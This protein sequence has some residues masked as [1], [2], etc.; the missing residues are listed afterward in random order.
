MFRIH[1]IFGFCTKRRLDNLFG[2]CLMCIAWLGIFGTFIGIF[3]NKFVIFINN[4]K[5]PVIM[6]A[7]REYLFG[8][9]HT[10]ANQNTMLPLWG[11]WIDIGSMIQASPGDML[12][13]INHSIAIT[14]AALAVIFV[15]MEM[16]DSKKEAASH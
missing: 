6:K 1:T 10:P 2:K 4:D 5:M 15:S 3:L 13:Y 9:H 14:A 7:G 11:D 12:M 8:D 16:E